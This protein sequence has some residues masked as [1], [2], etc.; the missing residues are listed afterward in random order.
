MKKEEQEMTAAKKAAEGEEKVTKTAEAAEVKEEVKE[1]K[2]PAKKAAGK[3]PPRKTSSPP[4]R[5]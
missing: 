5:G 1:E 3:A 4:S 2:K